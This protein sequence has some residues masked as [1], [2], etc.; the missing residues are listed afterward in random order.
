M[1]TKRTLAR[2]FRRLDRDEKGSALT[3][4]VIGLPVYI[5]LF[6]GILNLHQLEHGAV[7]VKAQAHSDM[8]EKAIEMQTQLMPDWDMQPAIGAGRAAY[9]HSQTGGKALDYVLDGENLVTA[10]G[11]SGGNMLES[12]TRVRPLD[13]VENIGS[14][15]GK[16]TY[17]INEEYIVEWEDSISNDLLNDGMRW[18]EFQNVTGNGF[19]G[20]LNSII[21]MSGMR[22]AVAAG[23]RYGISGGQAERTVNMIAFPDRTIEARSHVANP[24]RATSKYITFA[25]VRLA[26]TKE[27]RYDTAIKF[28]WIPSFE[29]PGGETYNPD[30]QQEYEDCMA[31]NAAAQQN[32]GET[33][34]C[35][36]PQDQVPG[37]GNERD[38]FFDNT[39][40][41]CQSWSCL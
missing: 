41:G 1:T 17:D 10:F 3:E 8:W 34:D 6:I 13:L 9:Y 23:V 39:T 38:E 26:M 7:L 32:G 36:N 28:E 12:Y 40:G 25:V 27:D 15:D 4:F 33:T 29:G 5:I 11:V 20:G 37:S 24:P 31:A 30:A 21:S 35:G 2:I 14:A 16:V 18:G 22:P 19:L